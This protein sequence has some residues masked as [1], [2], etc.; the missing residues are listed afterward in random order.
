MDAGTPTGGLLKVSNKNKKGNVKI[1]EWTWGQNITKIEY[2]ISII[3]RLCLL[4]KKYH[5]LYH[6]L[7]SLFLS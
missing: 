6:F 5:T 4:K 2:D 3:K 7:F 1:F